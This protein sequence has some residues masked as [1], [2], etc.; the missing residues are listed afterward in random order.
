MQ[1]WIGF[2][3][4]VGDAFNEMN[5][6]STNDVDSISIKFL[7]GGGY[8]IICIR[9]CICTCI[10]PMN[11]IAMGSVWNQ[12]ACNVTIIHVYH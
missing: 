12:F 4:S 9:V 1:I 11:K 8:D 7:R 5:K 6:N 3:I 2:D 10:P